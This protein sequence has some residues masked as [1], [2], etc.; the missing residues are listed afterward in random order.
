MRVTVTGATGLIGLQLISALKARGDE[1]TVLSRDPERAGQRLAV[2][3]VAWD[4]LVDSAP[5]SALA[6]ADAVVHL[7]GEPVAQR[8]SAHVKEQIRVS[9]VKGTANL[10]A[11]LRDAGPR[12]RVLVSS[13]ASGYYGDRGDEPLT[14]AAT[15]GSDFLAEVC[16][17]WEHGAEE[18][19]ALGLR[20]T[21]VR[22]GVVLSSDGGALKTMLPPFKAGVGGP[23]AGG[24]QYIPWIHL[25][26]IVGIYLAALGGE[27][28]SGPV[29]GCAP[30]AVT[31]KELS[32]ALGHA[33]HRPAVMPIPAFALRVLYGDMAQLVTGGQRMIPERTLALGYEFRHPDLGEALSSAL[34][35][36]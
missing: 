35:K 14:E 5:V 27:G 10:V 30:G 4:P 3:A 18:G 22:T 11:G 17:E 16:Q 34:D 21:R 25:D 15:P 31:N 2:R 28:W 32:Q 33:L 24:R 29:N 7:A 26:D 19:E 12:P 6:D 23:V 36:G 20:V 1:V 13:S 9:R 8:W